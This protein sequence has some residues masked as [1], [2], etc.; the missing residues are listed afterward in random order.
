MVATAEKTG[1][2]GQ[3]LQTV[4]EYFEDEG[5]RALR[6]LIKV[7]EPTIIVGLGGLVAMVVLSVM[8]PLLDVSTMSH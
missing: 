4:G 1:K 6:D 2:L 3:V 8:L 5:E 7:L